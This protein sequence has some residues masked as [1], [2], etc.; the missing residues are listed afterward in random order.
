MNRVELDVQAT[1]PERSS[2]ADSRRTV[3][4]TSLHQPISGIVKVRVQRQMYRA[5]ACEIGFETSGS[6]RGM[7]C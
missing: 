7:P 1:D 5:P 4:K 6:Q 3:A 2:T